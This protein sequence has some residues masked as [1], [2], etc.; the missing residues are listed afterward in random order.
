MHIIN[1][2]LTSIK[3]VFLT[4]KLRNAKRR[5]FE[6]E[7]KPFRNHALPSYYARDARHGFP[8]HHGS[9]PRHT[10]EAQ[11]RHTRLH[12]CPPPEDDRHSHLDRSLHHTASEAD[13]HFLHL[14]PRKRILHRR[15]H[16]LD[17]SQTNLGLQP[18]L[19]HQVRQLRAIHPCPL[20]LP[21][22]L[23]RR[24]PLPSQQESNQ[25]CSHSDY[26]S[27]TRSTI[28]RDFQN[29]QTEREIFSV[30]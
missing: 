19:L 10:Q 28:I 5:H 11:G 2:S 22:D 12:R 20:A 3:L 4:Y 8:D 30:M 21:L 23:C 27:N 1:P 25:Q 9:T 18:R 15:R 16:G 14:L 7:K 26:Q 29:T 6:P 17:V 24:T 13:L